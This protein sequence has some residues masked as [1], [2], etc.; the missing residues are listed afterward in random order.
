MYEIHATS[1]LKGRRETVWAVVADVAG[2]PSW[3]PHEESVRL[4]GPFGPGTTG[5]SKPSPDHKDV[6][7]RTGCL[8]TVA[9]VS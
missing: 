7:R 3:D 2:W 9:T 5:W 6:T 1:T 8:V 4:D